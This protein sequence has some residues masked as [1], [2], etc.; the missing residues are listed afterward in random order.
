MTSGFQNC[1]GIIE[2]DLLN[3]IIVEKNGFKNCTGIK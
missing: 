2:I 1:T 3:I